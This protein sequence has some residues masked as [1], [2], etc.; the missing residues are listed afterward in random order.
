[1][2][3]ADDFLLPRQVLVTI[4]SSRKGFIEHDLRQTV[5]L[6]EC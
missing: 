3:W 5:D 2:Q 1:M 6:N 4:Y